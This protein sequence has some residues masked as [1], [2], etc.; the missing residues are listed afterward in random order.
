MVCMDIDL[1]EDLQ[2][3]KESFV[4]GLT[5]K[6]AIFSFL[7]LGVG[8]GIVLLLYK[9]IGIT[10]SCYVA[11]PFVVPLALTGF[12]NYHGLTFWQF[13]SRLLYYSFFNRPL[14]Y[15]STESVEG[16]KQLFLEEKQEQ[17]LRQEKAE[18]EEK[19]KK[20]EDVHM[21]RRKAIRI[22]VA[23][24]GLFAAGAAAAAWYKYNH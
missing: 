14:V 17:K 19:K 13:A 7:A 6:Q 9:K 21:V 4:L 23:V 22:V 5:V 20:K 3:Y 2:Y 10:L 15:R 16:L 8:T 1:S 11:T 24:I 18:K 12:Y